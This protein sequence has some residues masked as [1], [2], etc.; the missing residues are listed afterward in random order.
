MQ[1][2]RNKRERERERERPPKSWKCIFVQPEERNR[3]RGLN[4]AVDD[5]DDDDDDVED[6]DFFGGHSAYDIKRH[7]YLHISRRILLSQ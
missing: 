6:D 5:D 7:G 2:Q 1:F 4:L 3:A